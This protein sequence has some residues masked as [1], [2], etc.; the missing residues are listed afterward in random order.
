MHHSHYI[1]KI[2]KTDKIPNKQAILLKT[3]TLY[4]KVSGFVQ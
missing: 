1:I 3:L 2:I 4:E